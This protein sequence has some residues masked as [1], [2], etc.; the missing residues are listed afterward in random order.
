MFT[1]ETPTHVIDLYEEEASRWGQVI[2]AEALTARALADEAAADF[3]KVPEAIRWIFRKLYEAS[4]GRYQKEINAW[5]V[6][7]G[8]SSGTA[9]LLNCL[10]E[11]S[12]LEVSRLGS[13]LLGCTAGIRWIDGVGMAH[14]RALDWPLA[15]LGNATRLF[16]FRRGA[17]EFYSV[18]FP[19]YV[20]VLSGMLP[21]CY[22]AT[23]NWAPPA[24]TPTFNFGPAFLLRETL[25]E[26][27]TYDEAVDVLTHTHLSTSVFFTLC[28]VERGQACIIERTQTQ[29]VVRKAGESAAQANHHVAPDFA[30]NNRP[31]CEL[32]EGE[33]ESA[34]AYSQRRAQAL[35]DRLASYKASSGLDSLVAVLEA[36][37]VTND[38]T[39]QRMIFCPGRGTVKVWRRLE[40]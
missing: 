3:E 8:V 26:C 6:A 23:I 20:G 18:G 9:T 14:V 2:A 24:S 37:P 1:S 40:P 34:Y 35:E 11:L 39:Y 27:D 32:D 30:P 25:E 31:M 5:A 16:R 10:Y 17:R 13:K 4:G 29:A 22:S 36:D 38:S 12:H 21:G 15:N 28:G 33:V 7:L 19:G